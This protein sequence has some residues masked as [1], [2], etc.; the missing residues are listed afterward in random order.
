MYETRK[1]SSVSYS[2]PLLTSSRNVPTGL[3]ESELCS[4]CTQSHSVGQHKRRSLHTG[5]K[6]QAYNTETKP[7]VHGRLCGW[8]LVGERL[9]KLL[10][11]RDQFEHRRR[12]LLHANTHSQQGGDR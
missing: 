1:H 7:T 2:V 8:Q 10:I 4:D 11:P 12:E 3:R 5:A 6:P 9:Q